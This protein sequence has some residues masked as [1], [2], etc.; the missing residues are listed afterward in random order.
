MIHT[1]PAPVAIEPSLF[2][3]PVRMVAAIAPLFRSTRAMVLSPQFGTHRLPNPTA[4]PEQGPFPTGM[5][6][7]DVFVFGS[8]RATL[9]FGRFETHTDSSTAIQS[10][11]P[12]Y[13]NTA[14]GLRRSI[15]ILTPGVFTP[16]FGVGDVCTTRHPS[17]K[18]VTN[19]SIW[20]QHNNPTCG[21][22]C[23]S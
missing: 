5:T 3:M 13:G 9:S 16:G 21:S 7:A 6:A 4:N 12:G 20:A 11:A 14:S 10:G 1:L 19:R 18:H 23:S 2:A 22:S 15:G 17:A 8:K